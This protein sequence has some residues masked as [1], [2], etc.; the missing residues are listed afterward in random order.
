MR[1]DE[2]LKAAK[3][4]RKSTTIPEAKLW[5][6]LR[7]RQLEG[8]KFRRQAPIEKYVVDFVCSEK[9]LVVELDGWTHSTPDEIAHDE[10]R[11]SFLNAE[12]F[13]VIRFTNIEIMQDIDGLLKLIVDELQK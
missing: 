12:G 13:R 2:N 6:Q 4:L 5:E 7:N 9:M 1:N 11:T 8:F 10:H 3:S